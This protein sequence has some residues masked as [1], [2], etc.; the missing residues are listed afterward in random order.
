MSLKDNVKIAATAQG[1]DVADVIAQLG[2][3]SGTY[4]KR[5]AGDPRV[6][7]LEEIAAV[8]GVEPMTL[9]HGGP[10]LLE[11]ISVC[12]SLTLAA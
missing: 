3:N 6:S 9:L 4:Y 7:H 10:D 8:L 1:K 2:W 5:V 11:R 12:E